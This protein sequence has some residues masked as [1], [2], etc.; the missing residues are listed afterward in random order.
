MAKGNS[1]TT[2]WARSYEVRTEKGQLLGRNRRMLKLIKTNEILPTEEESEEEEFEEEHE[3]R[4][5]GVEEEEEQEE[6]QD[7]DIHQEAAEKEQE[8]KTRSG[9]VVQLP[10]RF[11]DYDMS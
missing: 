5:E 1:T 7:E 4:N 2:L 11:K 3:E 9:R 8:K 6:E 10:I